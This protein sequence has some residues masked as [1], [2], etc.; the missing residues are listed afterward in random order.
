M[1][2][3]TESQGLW[4]TLLAP[5]ARPAMTSTLP[6]PPTFWDRGVCKMSGITV[7]SSWLDPYQIASSAESGCEPPLRALSCLMAT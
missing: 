4:I 3:S 1:M 2:G 7:N 5:Q 6:G